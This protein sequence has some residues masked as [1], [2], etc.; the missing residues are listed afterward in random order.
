VSEFNVIKWRIWRPLGCVL[1]ALAIC[2]FVPVSAPGSSDGVVLTLGSVDNLPPY[3]FRKDGKLTGASV[4]IVKE[5]AYR[6][7][8]GVRIEVKPWARVLLDVEEGIVDGAFSAYHTPEREEFC[9]YT[10]VLHYDELR[11]A[12]KKGHK[13]VYSGIQSLAGKLVGKGRGVFVS[14]EFRQAVASGLL[15]VCETDDMKMTNVKMLHE[16]RLDAVIGSPVSIREYA[17]ELGY[18]DII[19]LPGELK[20]AIP[21]YL[22]LSKNSPLQE[23]AAWQSK[24]TRLLDQMRADGTIRAI[25]ERYGMVDVQ[26]P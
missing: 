13:F 8:F 11:I 12:V 22:V 9:L 7:G 24:M 1:A 20:K 15:S 26:I 6:G 4:D 14:E 2:L 16:G 3:V 17:R 25:Y 23:K 19:I 21:A 10:G 5:L 18:E